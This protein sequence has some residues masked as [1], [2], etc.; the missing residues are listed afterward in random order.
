M[1]ARCFTQSTAINA[2]VERVELAYGILK[3]VLQKQQS[4]HAEKLMI[5]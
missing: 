4:A 2:A 5:G 1:C 3:L